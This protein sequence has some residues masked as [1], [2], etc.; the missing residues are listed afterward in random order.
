[1]HLISYRVHMHKTKF[2]MSA[3]LIVLTSASAQ[4]SDVSLQYSPSYT[5]CLKQAKSENERNHCY[6]AEVNFQ[7]KR[8]NKAYATLIKSKSPEEVKIYETAQKDWIHWRDETYMLL[9][10][11]VAGAWETVSVISS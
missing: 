8:L 9:G 4:T 6:Q 1:L 3:G 2:L 7:K 11:H 5:P 10:N